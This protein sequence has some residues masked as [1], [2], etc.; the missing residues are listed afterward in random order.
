MKKWGYY[1]QSYQRRM[2]LKDEYYKFGLEKLNYKSKKDLY[3]N[4]YLKAIV[5][6]F[7]R[8]DKSVA[9]E[10]DI[11]DRFVWDLEREN[12]LTKDYIQNYI[13]QLDFERQHFVS[14]SEKG[15]TDIVF[16]LAGFDR[17]TIEC[18]RLF[19]E[20]S[21]NEEYINEGLKRFVELKYSENE[22]YAG[23]IGF[24]VS[25]NIRTITEDLNT[26]VGNY[27]FVLEQRSLLREKCIGWEYSFQSKH[28]RTNNTK[29]HV[30]HLFFEFLNTI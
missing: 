21:K 5:D 9:L 15:R 23:M 3:E 27:F 22:G 26:K 8:I 13:L 16:S 10:N 11:R 30:Y 19:K 4:L 17:F 24:V 1:Y 14:E 18:K 28:H 2:K 7:H 6:T 20:P 25:G 29:I 12:K